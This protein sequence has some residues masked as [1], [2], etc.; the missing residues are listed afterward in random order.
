M[1]ISFAIHPEKAPKPLNRKS[2]ALA[3]NVHNLNI[4]ER[5]AA[6]GGGG[7]GDGGGIPEA[8]DAT[9]MLFGGGGSTAVPSDMVRIER[10][11]VQICDCA[12]IGKQ[13]A[14]TGIKIGGPIGGK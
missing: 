9:T 8:G 6:G 1:L 3:S 11:S 14:A 2:A 5:E 4:L 7:G 12:V 13:K 10:A